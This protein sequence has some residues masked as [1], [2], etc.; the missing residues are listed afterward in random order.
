MP[1]GSSAVLLIDRE[2]LWRKLFAFDQDFHTNAV[3]SAD[4]ATADAKR[5]AIQRLV[6]HGQHGPLRAML[7]QRIQYWM[8]SDI[9]PPFWRFFENTVTLMRDAR[10]SKKRRHELTFF[11]AEQLTMAMQFAEDAFATCVEIA[12]MMD[13]TPHYQSDEDVVRGVRGIRRGESMMDQLK[14]SFRSVLFEDSE[15]TAVRPH[16]PWGFVIFH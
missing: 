9:A 4:S 13:A 11:C 3:L 16:L 6:D 10:R 8:R 14:A 5:A 7:E 12:S 2:L 15:R 1:D